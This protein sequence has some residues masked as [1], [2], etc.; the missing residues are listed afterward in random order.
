MNNLD[1]LTIRIALID[2]KEVYYDVCAKE[3]WIEHDIERPTYDETKFEY[4][5]FGH[6]HTIDG[7]PNTSYELD[8][9][10]NR[11]KFC[12]EDVIECLHFWQRLF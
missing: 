2:G 8:G 5:G 12:G 11:K 7:I 10:G 3:R 6:I 4:V 9:K 1:K